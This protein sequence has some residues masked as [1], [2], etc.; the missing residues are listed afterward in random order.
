MEISL[1]L[2]DLRGGGAERVQLVLA[3]EF[4]RT[5]H[6][7]EFVVMQARGELLGEAQDHYAVADL[8][9][10]RARN[11][12]LA[13]ARYLRRRRPSALLAAMWP[14][15]VIAPL[16]ARL[17]RHSCRVV[18]SE[19]GI[20]SKQYQDWGWL[21]QAMLRSSAVLGYRFADHRVGVCSGLVQDMARLSRMP[22]DGFKAIHNPVPGRPMPSS[23]AIGHA[24]GLWAVPPGGRILTVGTMK[25]VKNHP[26]LLRAFA[27]LDRP[28]ARLMFVGDGA[29]RDA[30]LA[31]AQELGVADRVIFAGFHHDPTPFYH[32]ADLFVLSSNSEGFG[33]VIVEAMACGTP[34]VST[35]CPSGPAEVLDYGRF[36]RLTP[37]KDVNALCRAM[38]DALDADVDKEAL[39]RRAAEFAPE[40]AARK[41][42]DLLAL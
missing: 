7:V 21:H 20:L 34:V 41:Y 3:R 31:L 11:L 2:P 42:L 17:S 22:A 16:A 37:V 1:L 35:D 32:S 23:E 12:P 38:S 13:L 25:A 6:A 5:G 29:G 27:Q 19:H 36:G 8:A 14:L 15:T 30:L 24:D 10:P 40:I 9:V 26:L 39:Q 28:E 33:N 18:I 4:V